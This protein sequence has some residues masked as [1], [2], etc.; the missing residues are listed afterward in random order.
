MEPEEYVVIEQPIAGTLVYKVQ[1]VP[2]GNIR[3]LH[4]KLLLA[5]GV[6]LDLDN[7]LDDS[8]LDEDSDSDDSTV[9]TDPKI[10]LF[11]KKKTQEEKSSKDQSHNEI[12]ERKPQSKE[13]KHV[14]LNLK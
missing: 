2:G 6:K 14:D 9:E 4:R 3:T 1:P 12:D 8:I 7:K 11:G 5:L 13:E 10:K